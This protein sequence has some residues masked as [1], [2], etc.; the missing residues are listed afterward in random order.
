MSKA[1]VIDK[2]I[3]F[4]GGKSS[5]IQL[6]GEMD[7]AV[8]DSMINVLTAP[9]GPNNMAPWQDPVDARAAKPLDSGFARG[10]WVGKESH[11]LASGEFDSHG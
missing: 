11:C 4:L 7:V 9:P 6:K 5:K 3:K 10:P 8:I 1:A 2:S